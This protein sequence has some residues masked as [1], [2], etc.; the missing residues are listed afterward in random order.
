MTS[1]KL[2]KF[3]SILSGQSKRFL[4]AKAGLGWKCKKRSPL[5]TPR[6]F[7]VLNPVSDFRIT[8]SK[9]AK[10]KA[11]T[12]SCNRELQYFGNLGS[13]LS[14]GS[15]RGSSNFISFRIECCQEELDETKN[16]LDNQDP[17][18]SHEIPHTLS[19]YPYRMTIPLRHKY[20]QR[21]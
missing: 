10:H 18:E 5:D 21:I 17:E 12:H 20:L 8:T 11:S 14:N 13:Y 19:P 3:I 6:F 1:D 7:V 16:A 15:V 4:A 2:S 9:A